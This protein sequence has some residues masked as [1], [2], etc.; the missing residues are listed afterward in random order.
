M[1]DSDNINETSTEN[2]RESSN[3]NSESVNAAQNNNNSES[4]KNV[5]DDIKSKN[6]DNSNDEAT[7]KNDDNSNDEAKQKN[8]SE[9][10]NT[11]RGPRKATLKDKI[12]SKYN[13]SK[14]GKTV[15][16]VKKAKKSINDLKQS[17]QMA[18]DSNKVNKLSKEDKK[19]PEKVAEHKAK[20]KSQKKA[21]RKATR[22]HL[23]TGAKRKATE[24][25]KKMDNT[26]V[27]R[28]IKRL[29]E[30][31]VKMIRF[32][33]NH[34]TIVTI[35]ATIVIFGTSIGLWVS[36]IVTGLGNTPHY[37]CDIEASMAVKR[38]P[39]FQQYCS[40]LRT[41]N[42]SSL[43][44]HYIIQ[45]GSGPCLA[46]SRANLVLRYYDLMGV[47][48]YDYLWNEKG[49]YIPG[50]TFTNIKNDTNSPGYTLRSVI[51]SFSSGISTYKVSPY[52]M[53]HGYL[54]FDAKNGSKTKTNGLDTMANWGYIRDESINIGEW[55]GLDAVIDSQSENENWVW[56]LSLLNF[57]KGTT[58]SVSDLNIDVK[59]EDIE[60]HVRTTDAG[61]NGDFSGIQQATARQRYNEMIQILS[62]EVPTACTDAGVLMYYATPTTHHAVLITSYDPANPEYQFT[63]IDP[64]IGTAGGFEGPLVQDGPYSIKSH[65]SKVL[66]ML[67]N[68][69]Y[70][71]DCKLCG[72]FYVQVD[73][74]WASMLPVKVSN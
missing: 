36:S 67:S 33:A 25:S 50:Y 30:K 64:G 16:K 71:A 56:D 15:A 63:I 55:E 52:K 51:N 23:R 62:G 1:T 17:R 49:S 14:I 66:A 47:N 3:T 42:V 43:Q 45:D 4:R 19:D 46:C 11:T 8:K 31:A 29:F 35:V 9:K 7:S 18:R 41:F 37:Y 74:D 38:S 20:L 26:E 72:I 24:I 12:K 60:C 53:T 10:R 69:G 28:K 39:V 57:S 61:Y 70:S 13:H 59:V 27:G 44:G 58:W 48:V 22:Q 54:W 5:D 68:Q 73:P 21:V 65:S 32:I 6:D 2:T 40:E 34:L